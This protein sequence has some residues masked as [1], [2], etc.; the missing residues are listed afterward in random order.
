MIVGAIE[1]HQTSQHWDNARRSRRRNH[2]DSESVRATATV[3]TLKNSIFLEP[4]CAWWGST[5]RLRRNNQ[6]QPTIDRLGAVLRAAPA[7]R[8][9]AAPA[10]PH[11]TV[12]PVPTSR[13]R[14]APGPHRT[15]LW[16]PHVTTASVSTSRLRAAPG[17]RRTVPGAL[18]VTAAPF[19]TSWLRA[20]LGPRMTAPGAPCVTAALVLTSR[21]MVAPRL[22][23]VLWAPAPTSRRRVAPGALRVTVAPGRMKTVEPSSSEN[24]AP[25]EFFLAPAARCRA[26]PGALRVPVAPG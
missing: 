17:P 5:R 4:Y 2:D 6:K 24:R 22:T 20:P 21:L 11:V 9:R 10:A 15:A 13:L 25:E 8:R 18:R 7:S 14:V 16:A 26:A 23:H 19:P 1:E 3:R 12:V